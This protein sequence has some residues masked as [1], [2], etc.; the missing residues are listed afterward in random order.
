MFIM[1]EVFYVIL[2][3]FLS[4]ST[5]YIKDFENNKRENLA[6]LDVL[7]SEFTQLHQ[8]LIEDYK[9]QLEDNSSLYVSPSFALSNKWWDSNKL[10]YMRRLPIEAKQFDKWNR[11]NEDIDLT[12]ASPEEKAN[13]A[14][15]TKETKNSLEQAIKYWQQ[16]WYII[17][18]HRLK[19]K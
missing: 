9:S 14:S 1:N 11:V 16:S 12:K 13:Y 8:A 7:I 10:L 4:F 3:W 6:L 15:L 19:H 17:L 5:M 18:L 2:G